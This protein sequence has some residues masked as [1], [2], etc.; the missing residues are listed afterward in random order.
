LN[1]DDSVISR[2]HISAVL[3]IAA[4]VWGVA[5]IL[6]G[7]PVTAAW[8]RPF[9]VVVGVMVLVLSI[10]DR[11]LWRLRWLRP[12]LFNMPDLNGTWKVVI[13]PTAPE[14]SPHQ[15]IAYMVIRQTFSTVSLRLLT[16]ES[17]SETLSAHV[18][19][20]DD[21]TCNLAAVYRNTP[22]LQVRERSPLHHGAL[23]LNVQGDPPE[24]LAGQYWTDRLSQGE[25]MLSAR[26]P[27]LAHSF[28]QATR[29]TAGE[30][31]SA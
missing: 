16:A 2:L 7:V 20:C 18:V 15:V 6:A 14:T 19:R 22:R 12:W 10:A 1:E 4:G 27:A 5:L 24:S 23:L 25:L 11:W 26:S 29:L 8:F 13:H 3:V 9:S 30:E 28:D 17:H 31:G 21:G